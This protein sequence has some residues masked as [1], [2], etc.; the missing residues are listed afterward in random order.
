VTRATC[1]VCG[2]HALAAGWAVIEGAPWPVCAT[3]ARVTGAALQDRATV[4]RIMAR[5]TLQAAYGRAAVL[6][7]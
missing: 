3:C 6:S 7:G 5:R 1:G 2:E 4:R